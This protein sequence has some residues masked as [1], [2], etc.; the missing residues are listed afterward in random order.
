VENFT[1]SQKNKNVA[2]PCIIMIS[3]NKINSCLEPKWPLQCLLMLQDIHQHHTIIKCFLKT[4][5]VLF[6]D[7]TSSNLLI[8]GKLYKVN[9]T[10]SHASVL[11][12]KFYV[13]DDLISSISIGCNDEIIVMFIE[14]INSNWHRVL[15]NGQVVR[16]Y[17]ALELKP[18]QYHPIST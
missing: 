15:W 2:A 6:Q 16:I 17:S 4:S 5:F 14:T 12:P 11:N 1:R 7:T 18:I 13:Y 3:I 10:D 9:R 8:P